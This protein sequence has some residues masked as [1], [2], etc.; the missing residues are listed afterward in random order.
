MQGGQHDL[1]SCHHLDD[2]GCDV[3]IVDTFDLSTCI[4]ELIG[5]ACMR[6]RVSLTKSNSSAS[7]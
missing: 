7:C 4:H 3:A 5:S 1:L 2:T 6:M